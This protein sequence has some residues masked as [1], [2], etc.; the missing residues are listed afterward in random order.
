MFTQHC[1]HADVT[2]GATMGAV[3]F[4]M[5]GQYVEGY[6]AAAFGFGQSGTRYVTLS[7]WVKSTKTGTFCICATNSAWNRSYIA[8]YT[9]SSSDTWEKKTV[10]F[11]VDTS[12]TWLYDSGIGLR[13]YWVLA[14]GSLYHTTAGS[15][16][17]GTYFATA[18]QVNALDSTSN[19]FKLALIQLEAGSVATPFETRS[20]G[21]ELALCQRYF[22]R[23]GN[24]GSTYL[25]PTVGQRVL[26]N[27]IDGF[28][29]PP[30]TMRIAPTISHSGPS[31]VAATPSGNQI[32]FYNYWTPGYATISGAL[33]LSFAASTPTGVLFRATA[34]TSFSG[35]SG[36]TGQWYFGSTAYV[37]LFA[38]I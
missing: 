25:V 2:T 36:N 18:N 29:S 5:V 32:S 21:Q 28:I 31:Y 33:T 38:E 17:A 3:D 13:I 8:E 19:N 35:S 30:V 16:Q 1:L 4:Y 10:T 23:L 6:N 12:G 27:I 24:T 37:D 9:V 15:W 34:G 26:T 20:I 7:F 11:A 14:C 22:Y